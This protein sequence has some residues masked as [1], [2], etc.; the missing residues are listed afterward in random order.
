MRPTPRSARPSRRFA[1][2]LLVAAML[3]AALTFATP[4]VHAQDSGPCGPGPARHALPPAAPLSTASTV[5]LTLECRD[6]SG[7]LMPAR[8]RV[9]ASDATSYPRPPAPAVLANDGKGGY[10]YLLDGTATIRIPTGST[11]ITIGRGFEWAPIDV[12]AVVSGDTTLS[13]TMTR[14]TDMGA[15]RWYGGDVHVHMDHPPLEYAM[16]PPLVKTVAQAE[17]LTVTHL[18]DGPLGFIGA[19]D[20][21]SDSTTVL[22][23]S[24]EHRNQT[25][26]H[27][28]LPGLAMPVANECCLAPEEPP[29]PTTTD[30]ARQ[31]AGTGAIF[32]L[33]H[34]HTTND[35]EAFLNWPG[36]GLGRDLPV[37]AGLG[38]LDAMEVASYSND[39]DLDTADWYDLLAVGIAPSPV[40]GTDG[41]LNWTNQPPAGGWRVY[42]QLGR[43]QTFSYANWLEA[44]RAG[45]T[46]VSSYPLIQN[47]T[48]NG[49]G[50]GGTLEAPDD[51]TTL[52]VR[53]HVLCGVTIR[54]IAL[55]ADGV[56]IWSRPWTAWPLPT[57]KDTA[58]VLRMPTPS[59][60]A[61]RVEGPVGHPHPA[62]QPP[63]A[64]SNAVRLLR[65]DQP[66]VDPAAA[67]RWVQRLDRLVTVLDARGAWD[68]TWK[69][70]SVMTRIVRARAVFDALAHPVL[71][72]APPSPRAAAPRVV[73]NPAFGAVQLVGFPGGV[74]IFDPAGRRVARL[75]DGV[76][77]W[78]GRDAL[79]RTR[80]GLYLA[81]SADGRHTAR[82]VVL[83]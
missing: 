43:G 57:E 7:A 18:L 81:R 55:V 32:T 63:V 10:F 5:L 22:Y 47:F 2:P 3:C 21:L 54:R 30:V 83:R 69:R 58:L 31:V 40:A 71:G 26:G 82:F 59:W 64:H 17:G 8:A 12:E 9:Q 52:V 37:L 23:W 11:R 75:R 19:P 41:V 44:V 33:A 4:A 39:P 46:F 66:R 29:Y 13:Y 24:Y 67:D 49:V 51:T 16:T 28:S 62:I 73:P 76:T 70:D 53:L 25:Y 20:P 27:V 79:G 38:L 42:A 1:P 50:P 77:R 6:P 80:P 36:V 60:M 68:A 14:F 45:R 72:A 48:V 65:N 74:D 78:D 61:L 34:P 56:E 15:S 35:D